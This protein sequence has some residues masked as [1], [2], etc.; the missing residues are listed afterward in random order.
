MSG[1]A[2]TART[3]KRQSKDSTPRA[4][5]SAG[6]AAAGRTEESSD[7]RSDSRGAGGPGSTQE[8]SRAA[9]VR[10]AQ[11]KGRTGKV[12]ARCTVWSSGDVRWGLAMD[13]ADT[14]GVKVTL[15]STPDGKDRVGAY[16]A[17]SCPLWWGAKH[18]EALDRALREHV[19]SLMCVRGL[20]P[21]ITGSGVHDNSLPAMGSKE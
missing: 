20:H 18:R 14:V 4:G 7:A 19:F 3:K 21:F 2:K 12:L 8:S 10:D 15:M 6:T 13:G 1:V 5:A 9:G 17:A 16:F 11:P